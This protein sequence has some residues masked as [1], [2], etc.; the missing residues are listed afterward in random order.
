M[1]WTQR[2][3]YICIAFHYRIS[4]Q[5]RAN[6]SE[7]P[8]KLCTTGKKVRQALEVFYHF[9]I[10]KN[11]CRRFMPVKP[12]VYRLNRSLPPQQVGS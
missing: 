6:L 4:D 10:D 11:A 8:S 5:V 3:T 1:R 7:L 9:T 12:W 2:T